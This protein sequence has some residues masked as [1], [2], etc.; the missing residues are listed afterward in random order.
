[1]I[2]QKKDNETYITGVYK[3][4][5][6]EKSAKK[7][8]K[9]I[10]IKRNSE[11]IQHSE[12]KR[13]RNIISIV[14]PII[15]PRYSNKKSESLSSSPRYLKNKKEINNDECNYK[16]Q[17]NNSMEN[18]KS[19]NKSYNFD[20][21]NNNS[22]NSF[23]NDSKNNSTINNNYC[24]TSLNNQKKLI[25]NKIECN[26]YLD[27]NNNNINNKS[28]NRY[29]TLLCKSHISKANILRQKL[30]N[31]ENGESNYKLF[32]KRELKME[33]KLKL[34]PYFL[35]RYSPRLLRRKNN[36]NKNKIYDKKD[37]YTIRTVIFNNQTIPYVDKIDVRK[38]KTI[39]PPIIIGS[40]YHLP[41]KSEDSI[42]FEKLNNEIE[43]F[44]KS[45]KKGKSIINKK[46]NKNDILKVMKK[47]KLIKCKNL[48]NK[49]KKEISDTK[50]KINNVY[51]KLK[52]S[53]NKFDD[54]NA[55]ENRDNLYDI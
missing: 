12:K 38:K 11:K 19:R 7:K 33:E 22:N 31:K 9:Y 15:R 25:I 53:L 36:E 3:K 10:R 6:E 21:S 29:N 18:S 42:K 23:D 51:N 35:K 32:L 54:W 48:I 37:E 1:M 20:N 4:R 27:N 30:F 8:F 44:E 2:N 55:P 52:I 41:D 40:R 47:R 17:K 13:G 16:T 28:P 24:I 43:K 5:E 34:F 49:T 50:N 26:L 14:F 39:F 46:I 45:V